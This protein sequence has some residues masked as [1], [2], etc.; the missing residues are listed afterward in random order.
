MVAQHRDVDTELIEQ[1]ADLPHVADVGVETG[2]DI[3]PGAGTG[4]GIN[5]GIRTRVLGEK[6]QDGVEH[7]VVAGEVGSDEAR[8]VS[9]RRQEADRQCSGLLGAA[10]EHPDVVADDLGH[11]GCTDRD[12]VRVIEGTGVLDAF[13]QVGLAAE[14]RSILGHGG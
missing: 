12:H 2:Q 8:R 3:D 1:P 11:A 5:H 14:Y 4:R 7:R 9:V 6:A 10:D 13:D